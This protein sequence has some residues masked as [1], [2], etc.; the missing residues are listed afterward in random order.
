MTDSHRYSAYPL[1]A[2]SVPRC[3]S[4]FYRG[5]QSCAVRASGGEAQ[6]HL[7][8]VRVGSVPSL[9]GGLEGKNILF[10]NH[11]IIYGGAP[12]PRG[13]WRRAPRRTPHMAASTPLTHRTRTQT[14][15][16]A[17]VSLPGATGQRAALAAATSSFG[18]ITTPRRRTAGDAAARASWPYVTHTHTHCRSTTQGVGRGEGG[19][20]LLGESLCL[21][22]GVHCER[23]HIYSRVSL[24]LC[25]ALYQPQERGAVTTGVTVH[26]TRSGPH[27]PGRVYTRVHPPDTVA[28]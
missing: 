6:S 22:R 12:H 16:L 23:R 14:R 20:R 1:L 15:A 8:C 13:A 10:S 9:G 7:S 27:T 11:A 24:S 21:S 2:R 5:T 3:V 4:P 25:S 18:R 19:S 26:R 28:R 17:D